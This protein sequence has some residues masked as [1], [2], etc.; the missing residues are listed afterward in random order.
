MNDNPSD[1]ARVR[2]IIPPESR[3]KPC[4]FC[5]TMVGYVATDCSG[6]LKVYQ[7]VCDICDIY[8]PRSRDVDEAIS[9]WNTRFP[10]I[11]PVGNSDDTLD[12]LALATEVGLISSGQV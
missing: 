12:A 10:T 6:Y 4:P 9:K 3:F 8:G 7:V 11:Y 5:G 1:P 2:D